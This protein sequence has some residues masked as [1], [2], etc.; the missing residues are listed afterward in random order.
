[1]KWRTGKLPLYILIIVGII[2]AI[3]AYLGLNTRVKYYARHYAEKLEAANLTRQLL[4]EV[5]EE[6]LARGLLI[7]DINDPNRT[8]L[9]GVQYSPITTE[10]GDLAAKLTTTNPNIAAMVIEL[11]D[12]AGVG[13]DDVVAVSFSGSFPALN[14]AVLAALEVIDARPVIIT[15]V[16]ASTWGANEPNWT[17]L[18]MEH[19]LHRKQMIHNRS[20]GASIGGIDDIGRG[21]SPEG[22]AMLTAAIERTRVIPLLGADLDEAIAAR[23]PVY[24]ADS[25]EPV[26]AFINV[27]G[28]AAALAGTDL[29]SGLVDR[30][31]HAQA[32]GLVGE[33]LRRGVNVVNLT[34]INHL[35]RRHGLP[36]RPVPIPPIGEGPLYYETR[37]SVALA[38]AL[39]I[40]LLVIMLVVLRVDVDHYLRGGR[41]KGVDHD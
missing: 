4:E 26:R 7:D 23:L 9:V 6:R 20:T 11:L 38:L 16:G 27:G 30:R 37:Y 17:Y 2:A 8:G 40:A 21:L 25:T 22:R 18:D 34:D 32:R 24:F 33:F 36:I 3:F 10:P 41:P 39:S 35:A 13:R 19:Y 29:P 5:K 14:I 28:G 12:R 1:M 15:S 31:V